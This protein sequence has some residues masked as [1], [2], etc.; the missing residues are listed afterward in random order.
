MRCEFKFNVSDINVFENNGMF[1]IAVCWN[2]TQKDK[3]EDLENGPLQKHGCSEIIA[4]NKYK[5]LSDL[6][7]YKIPK[8]DKVDQINLPTSI[9]IKRAEEAVFSAYIASKLYPN[10][11]SLTSMVLVLDKRFPRI[12]NMKSQGKSNV[13]TALTQ[14]KTKIL[15]HMHGDFYRWNNNFNPPQSTAKIKELLKN[16]FMADLPT[17]KDIKEVHVS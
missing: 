4:L 6:P 11:F 1:D 14:T 7:D 13:I 16:R 8:P 17:D 2:I 9:L 10:K 5:T 3:I 12:K 15:E